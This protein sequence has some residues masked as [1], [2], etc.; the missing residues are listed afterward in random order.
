MSRVVHLW[1]NGV[2]ETLDVAEH[3]VAEDEV[4]VAVLLAGVNFWEVLQRRGQV[5][6]SEP[7]PVGSEGVGVVVE[8]GAAVDGLH[9]G[10]RVAWSKVRGSYADLV[11]G[12][13]AAFTPVPDDVSDETAAGLL[14]QG[15]TAHYL[16]TDAW[17]LASGDSALVTAAAGGVGLLLTQLLV[18]RGVTVF[19]MTSDAEKAV[20][21]R[22]VGASAVL[23][24]ARGPS[25]LRSM[26]PEGLA[27]I[28]DS[29]GGQLPRELLPCLRV[30]GALVLFGAASG[31]ESDIGARDL[32]AGSYYLT[33]TGGRDYTRS[34]E[35]EAQRK[36]E[37]VSL[38]SAGA[39]SVRVGGRWPLADAATALD[40][41]ESRTTVGKLF[42]EPAAE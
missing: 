4:R 40:A 28:Y 12:P 15:V 21:V 36:Q 10:S 38:A 25:E 20:H 6:V 7:T 2:L 3:P 8:C 33:R 39:L 41:L 18:A 16:A 30:R 26:V 19:G 29:V 1:P 42:I 17:P 5:V 37:L 14:F 22:D 34:P 24:Y 31:S 27:A 35:E 9:V 11:Q 23:D 32:G 13:A